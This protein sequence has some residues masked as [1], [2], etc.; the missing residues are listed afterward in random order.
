LNNASATDKIKYKNT[1]NGIDHTCKKGIKAIERIKKEYRTS[2]PF[3]P[4]DLNLRAKSGNGATSI[5][6]MPITNATKTKGLK[7]TIYQ[8]LLKVHSGKLIHKHKGKKV[9]NK[10]FKGVGTPINED[11]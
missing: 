4:K 7:K 6:D 9:K 10:A 1:I 5:K 8:G 11:V 2:F 3:H